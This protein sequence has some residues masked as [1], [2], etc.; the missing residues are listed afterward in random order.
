MFFPFFDGFQS[1]LLTQQNRAD[2][3]NKKNDK[4]KG[5]DSSVSKKET[6]TH[7]HKREK[8][9]KQTHFLHMCIR[10][11]HF[12][13]IIIGTSE[14]DAQLVQ[15]FER[16]DDSFLCCLITTKAEERRK[17]GVSF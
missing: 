6:H 10:L 16:A 14:W 15:S 13:K 12:A 17:R 3:Q 7:T 9:K 4:C 1:L 11:Y 8:K 5:K 2:L